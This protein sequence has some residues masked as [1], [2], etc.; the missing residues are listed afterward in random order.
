MAIQKL[1]YYYW[2]VAVFH[3]AGAIQRAVNSPVFDYITMI[4][5]V[6]SALVQKKYS[7]FM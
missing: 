2:N 1:K 4:N 7:G 5:Y 3:Y 6:Q